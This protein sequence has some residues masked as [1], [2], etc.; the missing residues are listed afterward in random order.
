MSELHVSKIKRA[1]LIYAFIPLLV[2]FLISV[3]YYLHDKLDEYANQQLLNLEVKLEYDLNY[4]LQTIVTSL[5]R[6][7]SYI[8]QNQAKQSKVESD[9]L[10]LGY[11]SDI[12]S[13]TILSVV[14]KEFKI[15]SLL[16]RGKRAELESMLVSVQSSPH[17]SRMIFNSR[18]AHYEYSTKTDLLVSLPIISTPKQQAFLWAVINWQKFIN[19][20]FIVG[21]YLRNLDLIVKYND[22]IIHEE[23]NVAASL[24]KYQAVLPFKRGFSVTVAPTTYWYMEHIQLWA[25]AL[26]LMIVVTIGV[27]CYMVY[28]YKRSDDLK[29]KYV[30]MR[31]Q[32]SKEHDLYNKMSREYGLAIS[33]GQV[34]IWVWNVKTGE[35][36]W[37]EQMYLLYGIAKDSVV[38][39]DTWKNLVYSEDRDEAVRSV[40]LALSGEKNFNITYRT[41]VQ[42]TLKYIKANGV[43]ERSDDGEPLLF[44]GSNVDITSS[45]KAYKT[46]VTA[47]ITSWEINVKTGSL[48]LVGPLANV[49][50]LYASNGECNTIDSWQSLLSNESQKNYQDYLAEIEHRNHFPLMLEYEMQ[51]KAHEPIWVVDTALYSVHDE[52]GDVSIVHGYIQDITDR[53]KNEKSLIDNAKTDPLTKLYNVSV[54]KESLS[55]F[56]RGK[57]LSNERYAILYIDIDDF[58]R[59]NDCYGHSVGSDVLIEFANRLRS[60][61]RRSDIASR[62]GG[63]EFAVVLWNISSVEALTAFINNLIA[64]ITAVIRLDT[65]N[66]NLKV[67]VGVSLCPEHSTDVQAL[68]SLADKAMYQVK[69]AGKNSVKFYEA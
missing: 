5:S 48:K 11:L 21:K 6:L 36:T 44:I 52:Q 54:F 42:N 32:N 66:I 63:D 40:H 10:Y 35:L 49:I 39:Y 30:V 16:P 59:I 62:V 57:D 47:S 8:E 19:D 58:K 4:K 20:E 33:S 7:A 64:V 68:L 28:F 25:Y 24:S 1:F 43:V 69:Q 14:T 34:G 37:N 67:S 61:I 51:V 9:Q 45:V 41:I 65:I 12:Q 29:S 46:N 2:L 38:N 15:E 13:L 53:K 23:N 26:Y 50:E 27:A 55:K 3:A 17:A 18:Q 22:T 31:L 60:N 56:K